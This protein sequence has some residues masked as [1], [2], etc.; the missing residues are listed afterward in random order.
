MNLLGEVIKKAT[1][2]RIDDFAVQ[3][4]FTAL[5]ITEYEWVFLNPDIVYTSGDL[6]LRPRD[7]AKLGCLYLNDGIWNGRRIISK[8][9]VEYSTKEYITIPRA[10][11]ADE[12]GDKYCYQWF[13]RTDYLNSK[14]IDSFLRTGWGGQRISVFPSLDL[15]VVLTGGN[16]ATPEPVN[17]IITRYILPSV[18]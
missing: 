1:G 10:S 6:K 5:G 13:C 16:Y 9:W 18:H 12:N 4:L 14:P 7:M 17:E 2:L 11:W 15:V 8:E 3:Y